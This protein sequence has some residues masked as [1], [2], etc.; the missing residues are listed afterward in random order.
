VG[1]ASPSRHLFFIFA[2]G[3]ADINVSSPLVEIDTHMQGMRFP[4][5]IDSWIRSER[6]S[7]VGRQT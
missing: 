1:V 5:A 4:I 3:G 6:Q 2:G 7:W